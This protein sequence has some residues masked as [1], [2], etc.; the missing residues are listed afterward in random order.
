MDFFDIINMEKGS[1]IF[2]TKAMDRM[3]LDVQQLADYMQRSV[4]QGVVSKPVAIGYLV[5][6]LTEARMYFPKKY[7][8][9]LIGK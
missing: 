8:V 2:N 9:G 5:Q 6:A 1:R 4:D 7:S 3:P